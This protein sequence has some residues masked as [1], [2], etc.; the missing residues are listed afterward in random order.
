LIATIGLLS[1]L[2]DHGMNLHN[3]TRENLYSN[4]SLIVAISVPLALSV[5]SAILT[6]L[7]R[8]RR[9]R[10]GADPLAG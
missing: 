9:Q 1:R 2:D 6:A 5:L 3:V 7:P 4:S 10:H 8:A